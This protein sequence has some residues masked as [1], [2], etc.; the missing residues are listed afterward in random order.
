M[1]LAAVKLLLVPIIVTSETGAYVAHEAVDREVNCGSTMIQKGQALEQTAHITG[2][3][4][5]TL[6]TMQQNAPVHVTVHDS[7]APNGIPGESLPTLTNLSSLTG[8]ISSLLQRPFSQLQMYTNRT[9]EEESEEE[10]PKKPKKP[11]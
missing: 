5:D 7:D 11:K 2:Y 6:H 8:K 9:P 10:K 1:G 3:N 4:E